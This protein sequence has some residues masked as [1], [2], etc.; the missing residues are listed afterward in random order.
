MPRHTKRISPVRAWRVRYHLDG[1]EHRDVIVK[2]PNK[3]DAQWSAWDLT[4]SQAWRR[5]VLH[6]V[7]S[8]LSRACQDS[9]PP[10]DECTTSAS[11]FPD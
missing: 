8:D 2:A 6:V 3:L 5:R 7:L 11:A 4:R 10:S 1:A 9:P